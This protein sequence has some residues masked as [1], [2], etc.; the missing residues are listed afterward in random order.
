M[1]LKPTLELALE[2]EGLAAPN[3]IADVRGELVVAAVALVFFHELLTVPRGDTRLN[4]EPL[5][6]VP[7][8]P[9]PAETIES[10]VLM[11]LRAES[12][13]YLLGSTFY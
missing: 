5:K 12:A 6:F 8:M 11:G 1:P 9:A 13:S 3:P 4:K 7:R 2:S 10:L